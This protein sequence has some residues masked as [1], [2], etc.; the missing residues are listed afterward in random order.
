MASRPAIREI[1]AEHRRRYRYRRIMRELRRCG[2]VVNHKRVL[3]ILNEDNL[4]GVWRR[5][6]VATT[7]C[8][9]QFQV[10]LNLASRIELTGMNQLWVADI[11]YIRLK[12]EFVY[13][14]DVLDAFPRKVV[15][16]ALERTLAARLA[17]A[18]LEQ[19]MAQRHPPGL[20][21]HYQP[22]R[23]VC[24]RRLRPGFATPPDDPQHEPSGE[25]VR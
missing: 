3:R 17:I 11:N 21:H 19:A 18:A 8:E 1:A 12:K 13:L 20:V 16:W 23:A 4:L 14:A 24:V 10:H 9:H 15:G 7:D 5:A 6:F 2:I 22:G 25:P